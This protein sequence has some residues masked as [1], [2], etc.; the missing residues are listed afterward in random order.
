MSRSCEKKT[1]A[2]ASD[3]NY[4]LQPGLHVQFTK[5]TKSTNENYNI[6][7]DYGS[8]LNYSGRAGSFT[9]EP[10]IVANDVM[11]QE[12]L[13]GPF[14]AFYDILMMNTHYNCLD[15]CKEDPKAAKCKMGGFSHPRDCTK[16]ICPSGYGGPFCDQRVPMFTNYYPSTLVHLL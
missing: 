12:T 14:L 5:Q 9:G 11:Y 7:Y 6:T 13:G 8:I 1:L 4:V 10:V 15:K 3:L 2:R 16:C